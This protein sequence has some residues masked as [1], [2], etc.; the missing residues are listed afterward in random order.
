MGGHH[1]TVLEL[2]AESG[3]GKSVDDDAF[4]FDMVFTC[5]IGGSSLMVVRY[6]TT[7]SGKVPDEL[8]QKNSAIL[9]R[10]PASKAKKRRAVMLTW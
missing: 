1:V 8:C 4:H 5:H 10:M 6:D 7:L 9:C 2:D 3:I